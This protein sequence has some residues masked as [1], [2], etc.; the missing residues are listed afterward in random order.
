MSLDFSFVARKHKGKYTLV[1]KKYGVVVRA[2]ELLKATKELQERVEA[3]AREL[4]EAGVSLPAVE[5]DGFAFDRNTDSQLRH[6]NM[7][8]RGIAL[9]YW[10]FFSK[11]VVVLI[12][13]A[14][15]VLA[16]TALL[17]EFL[18]PR[19][20]IGMLLRHPVE[21]LVQMGDRA[22]AMPPN[23]VDQLK[24]AIRKIV[25]KAAPLVEEAKFP[26]PA[27]SP[28]ALPDAPKTK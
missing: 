19:S 17:S 13:V 14:V 6:D 3:V 18:G 22:E 25:A 20:P 15:I 23:E 11:L 10:F 26:P 8:G 9:E 1:A 12:F 7:S 16:E 2:G 5:E 21:F 27:V 4:H 28:S 24:L